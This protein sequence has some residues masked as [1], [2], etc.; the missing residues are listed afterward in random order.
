MADPSF[1]PQPIQSTTNNNSQR[2]FNYSNNYKGQYNGNRHNYNNRNSNYNRNSNHNTNNRDDARF[3]YSSDSNAN[4]DD[5]NAQKKDNYDYKKQNDK[6]Y[7]RPDQSDDQTTQQNETLQVQQPTQSNS[8]TNQQQQSPPPQQQPQ[9][10]SPP[11]PQQQTQQQQQSPPSQQQ[12]QETPQQQPQ[13]TPPSLNQKHNALNI[14]SGRNQNDHNAQR[15]G[16]FQN[17]RQNSNRGGYSKPPYNNNNYN[18]PNDYNGNRNNYNTQYNNRNNRPNQ[19]DNRN[20]RSRTNSNNYQQN[21]SNHQQNNNY[22]QNNN[23]YQQYPNDALKKI[24]CIMSDEV[25]SLTPI[26][27][28]L[29]MQNIGAD[30]IG[31]PPYDGKLLSDSQYPMNVPMNLVDF[32]VEGL[33]INQPEELRFLANKQFPKLTVLIINLPVQTPISFLT[34]DQP[35]KT[36]LGFFETSSLSADRSQTL[37]ADVLNTISNRQK[38]V[39]KIL[40]VKKNSFSNQELSEFTKECEVIALKD[41][42]VLNGDLISFDLHVLQYDFTQEKQNKIDA[43]IGKMFQAG[44]DQNS[45]FEFIVEP[46]YMF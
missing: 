1:N 2:R 34:P 33:A 12:A 46:V 41:N 43:F 24:L 38:T 29:K 15:R 27:D 11:P 10:Q 7:W 39:Y 14:T 26:E 31:N 35:D 44:Q 20:N 9:Q 18:R 5:N 16:G 17:R 4:Q 6:F 21:N 25:T 19:Y 22:Q 3:H 40:N 37:A 30:L 13:V 32:L 36:Q 42:I 8:T 45:K 23:S 28:A